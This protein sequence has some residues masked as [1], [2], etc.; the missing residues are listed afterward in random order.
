MHPLAVV[1]YADTPVDRYAVS[2]AHQ[3]GVGVVVVHEGSIPRLDPPIRLRQ[4]VQFHRVEKLSLDIVFE[5]AIALGASF[6]VVPDHGKASLPAL[7][8]G[9]VLA[10]H[11]TM[12]NDGP[13]FGMLMTKYRENRPSTPYG[14]ILVGTDSSPGSAIA[15]I[16][17][18]RVARHC[19]S[20]LRVTTVETGRRGFAPAR[21]RKSGRSL[22]AQRRVDTAP[23]NLAL[24][25]DVL[26]EEGIEAVFETRAGDPAG[27][28]LREIRCGAFDVFASP[29]L[30]AR[31]KRDA[32]HIGQTIRRVTRLSPIDQLIVFDPVSLGIR[33]HSAVEEIPAEAA[34]LLFD[35]PA[36]YPP[37]RAYRSNES[38]R[39]A[40]DEAAATT[41]P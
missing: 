37:S 26:A 38:M 41:D 30:G 31:E 40:H 33:K 29:I 17:A 11:A 8:E 25:C 28:L 22:S 6:V 7:R 5:Q 12:E 3:I 4:H 18:A 16:V 35:D 27:I 14:N 15:A 2:R 1:G 13:V 24:A 9:L 10:T 19:G 20:R 21:L 36:A 32:G 23:A 39:T 34:A